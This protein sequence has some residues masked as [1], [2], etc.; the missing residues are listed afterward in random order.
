MIK[1]IV[2][3]IFFIS[4]TVFSQNFFHEM[5]ES[6]IENT[7]K[8]IHKKNRS[9]S[10]RLIHISNYFVKMP[11]K[12]DP[13]GEGKNRPLYSFKEA[14]CV[15]FVE[16]VLAVT[17]Y[18]NLKDAVAFLQKIRYKNGDID[19]QKRNHFM[20]SQWIPNNTKNG[21]IKD[22]TQNVLDS[23]KISPKNMDLTLSEMKKTITKESYSNSLFK[24]FIKLIKDL[25][26]GEFS[27]KYIPLQ[28]LIDNLDIIKIPKGSIMT[29][30]RENKKDYPIVIS[31]L[32]FIYSYNNKYYFRSASYSR[33][34]KEVK[35][36]DLKKYISFYKNYT[37]DSNWPLIGVQFYSPNL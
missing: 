17:K 6:Q 13:L 11:Y 26:I 19:Y 22:I 1:N 25:P 8:T 35:D 29:L 36:F 14:D 28:V 23:I 9:I 2:T 7:I 24:K 5:G 3:F 32:G 20:I 10:N 4:T 27:V 15:T 21:L 18:S 31:H 37:K 33:K 12:N 30:V 34:H 16:T